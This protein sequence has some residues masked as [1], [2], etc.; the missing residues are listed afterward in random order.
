MQQTGGQVNELLNGSSTRRR[1]RGTKG[2][3]GGSD[4]G[5]QLGPIQFADRNVRDDP[6]A[7]EHERDRQRRDAVAIEDHALGIRDGQG[8]DAVRAQERRRDLSALARNRDEHD[9]AA[10]RGAE[11]G[12]DRQFVGARLAPRC[13]K[14][15]H[16]RT[17]C[18][19]GKTGRRTVAVEGK[20]GRRTTVRNVRE[21]RARQAVPACPGGRNGQRDQDNRKQRGQRNRACADAV[22][23]RA[24]A[25]GWVPLGE[26]AAI[27]QTRRRRRCATRRPSRA[28]RDE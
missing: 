21:A 13:P 17:A 23:T 8:I 15:Q 11:A 27:L 7:V 19:C 5:L 24:T 9:I 28:G 2:R 25:R 20:L 26:R 18:E 6:V 16:D 10:V 22:T 12:E 14:I 1:C 3:R 4:R